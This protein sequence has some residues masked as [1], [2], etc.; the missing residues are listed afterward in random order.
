[1]ALS[2]ISPPASFGPGGFRWLADIKA[3]G[4]GALLLPPQEYG[5]ALDDWGYQWYAGNF[6]VG[7]LLP[8][9]AFLPGMTLT[10]SVNSS[11]ARIAKPL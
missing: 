8:Q 9:R 1:M 7:M 4:V 3:Q 5:R 11:I 10:I 6:L 2:V